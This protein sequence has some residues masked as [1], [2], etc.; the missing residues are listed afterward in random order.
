[1]LV[2]QIYTEFMSLFIYGPDSEPDP[3]SDPILPALSTN[4]STS[5]DSNFTARIHT[6]TD[7][8]NF[9]ASSVSTVEGLRNAYSVG[10]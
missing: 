6:V 3:S 10:K 4:F 9:D 1:M 2:L 8:L 5:P 7:P